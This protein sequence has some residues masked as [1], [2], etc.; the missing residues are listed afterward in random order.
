MA[1]ITINEI[2]NT[3]A[4]NIGAS[5]FAT[6]ALPITASWGPGYVEPETLGAGVTR[7]DVLDTTVWQRFPATQQGMEAFVAA[8]R[9]PAANYRIAGDYSYQ[10]A[11]TLMT[12]GYDVLVCRLCPGTHSEGKFTASTK[13]FIVKA[14]YPGTFGNNLYVTLAKVPNRSYFNLIVY[15]V[16][17]SGTRRALEN[18]LFAF[19]IADATDS[20]P[21]INELESDFLTFAADGVIDDTVTFTESGIRLSGGSDRLAIP[22]STTSS[23]LL[24]GAR[25]MAADRFKAV[26]VA[27]DDI[28]NKEYFKAYD[29]L[30]EAAA[31]VDKIRAATLVYKEWLFTNA[32]YVY[33]L[34]KDKLSYSPQRI[35]SPGW[36]DQNVSDISGD[37]FNT[38]LDCVSPIHVKLMDV[39]YYSRCATALID[40][41][42][43]LKR[44][45]VYNESTSESEV[46]YAQMLARY[47]P[48]NASNDINFGLYQTHAGL[49]APWGS[50]TYVG[51]GKKC[52]APPA[53]LALLIQR[54]MI[55]NQASQY[56][57][58]LPTTRKH[59]VDI[60]TLDYTIGKKQLETWQKLGGVGVNII[61]TIPDLGTTLWG[62]STLFEVPPASYQALANLSTR[63]LVN[64]VK[65][66]VYRCGIQITFQYNNN[67]AYSAFYA[68]VT[69]LLD[70]MRNV[71]AIDG[72]YVKMAAD[73]N[74]LDQVN[75]NSVVGQIMLVVNG[76]INDITVDLIACPPGTDLTQFAE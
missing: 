55:L 69:P 33:D 62:N 38:R 67:Q 8:Y 29:A 74:G 54:A 61:T 35:I 18:L 75:A 49:F 52:P 12:A 71:G 39:S 44:T 7:D 21:H 64:A 19:D 25:S 41:P 6:V 68:G 51:M 66:L 70:T 15:A 47:Q 36:D 22:E 37:S 59:S 58:A 28:A 16:E 13:K 31:S 50:Y 11:M 73:V 65:D 56:E 20:V 26:G 72:Y 3:Y 23:Q 57:W 10:M 63:Y 24:A 2:S 42:K 4:Y 1:K 5:S 53:F 46:G 76:V 40:V 17:D 14:K 27:E 48:T 9:G 32:L 30:I 60:G 45:F 43:C 34:L